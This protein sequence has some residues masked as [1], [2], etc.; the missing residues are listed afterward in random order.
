M[1]FRTL[2]KTGLSVSEIGLGCEHLDR[3]PYKQAKE[4]I[5][6]AL[7]HG[8]N[9][10]DCFMPGKEIRENI[11]K[12]LGSNRKK[13]IIQGAVGSTDLRQQYDKSRD[14][15]IVKRYFDEMLRVFGYVDIAMLFFVDSDEE[16]SDVFAEEH[17]EYVR[18]LQKKG[19]VRYIGVSSHNPIIAKKA[20]E[21]G[22]PEVLFFSINPAF[23]MLPPD[24][25]ALAQFLE[26]FDTT[27]MQG[28]DPR[29][30]SLYRLCEQNNI[31]I[32][33]MKAL[34]GGKLTSPEH[35]PFAKP[36]TVP[37]CIHYALTRPAVSSA[38]LGCQTA[39]EVEEAMSYYAVGENE[40][41]YT[42]VLGSMRNNFKGDCVYCG[43]CQPCPVDIDIASVIKYLDIARLTPESVPP[44]AK[45]HYSSLTAS[46]GD[47]L[48]CGAC[49]E[50]CPFDVKIMNNMAEADRVFS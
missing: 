32:T 18:S 21:T 16:F 43:H 9:I 48:N 50:R 45:A 15:T 1:K 47:C 19:D 38:L 11:A 37:Q 3:K 25:D 17:L 12:A 8:M 31:G 36:M 4:T 44:S 33:V 30:S 22:I 40:R 14:M 39:T 6:A 26:D 49:E 41:D 7:A 20:L 28:I 35:T 27:L 34:G 2:G 42:E 13:V 24:E 23:D 46:G 10:F 29:R 5:D